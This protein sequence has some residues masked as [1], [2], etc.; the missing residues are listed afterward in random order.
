MLIAVAVHLGMLWQFPF[1]GGANKEAVV[2]EVG[3]E[4][5]TEN[6]VY[7]RMRQTFGNTQLPPSTMAVYVP[8]LIQRMVEDLAVAYQAERMGLRVSE[9]EVRRQ[10]R[11]DPNFAKLSPDQEAN[12]IQQM[13]YTVEEFKRAYRQNAVANMLNTMAAMTVVVTPQEVERMFRDA[14]EKIKLRYIDFPLDK[15][16]SGVTVTP[17]ELQVAY[18]RMKSSYSIPE[19]RN[20]QVILIDRD[21]VAATIPISEGQLRDYYEAHK[22]DFRVKDRVKLRHILFYTAGKAPDEVNKIRAKAQDVLKQAQAGADFA[23][24]ARKN[25]QDRATAGKGG[26]LGWLQREQ[27]P[28]SFADVAFKLK[29][30][31]TGDLVTTQFGF[32]IIWV[33]EKEPA[34]FQPF[35]KVKDQIA[36]RIGGQLAIDKMQTVAEQARAGLM[37]TPQNGEQIASKLGVQLVKV[38][39]L[40]PEG[41]IAGVGV[42]KELSTGIASLNKGQVSEA[43]QV[44]PTRLAI[45]VVTQVNPPRVL[46]FSEVERQVRE[47]LIAQKSNEAVQQEAKQ[48]TDM[49]A[50]NG[51]DIEAVA[52][53][54][55]LEVRT[56]EPFNRNGSVAATMAASFFGDIFSKPIGATVGPVNAGGLTVVVKLVGR[57]EPD[58]RDLERQRDSLA[59][60]LKDKKLSERRALFT[61]SIVNQLSKEGNIK[62]HKDVVDRLI[63]R[64]REN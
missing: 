63:S 27:L 12:A 3:G 61:D 11:S 26:D 23:T 33:E 59:K 22:D 10:I 57:I 51:G 6:M 56:S 4:K 50:S 18:S 13:G 8:M 37:R 16:K 19:S 24:L 31:E 17:A 28:P 32:H 60:N 35:E 39:D 14:N 42:N 5:I 30:G 25:S 58:M 9:A 44:R 40:L 41:I 52:K 46:P 29:P 1:G 47:A 34:G 53:S 54:F 49:L 21:Q 20:A 36:P 15:F 7:R 43:I 64:Y 62:F 55:G 38:D 48:A 2:A 45:A